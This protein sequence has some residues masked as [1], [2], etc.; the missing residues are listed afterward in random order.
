MDIVIISGFLG[1]GKTTTLNHFINSAK[2]Q[3]QTPAVIMN[4]FGS[5]SVDS[6]LIDDSIG[7]CE[8]INGCI[9][10]EM[11]SNVTDQ[12]HDIY[13]DYQPD[14]VFIECSGIAHPLEVL[15]AC[16]T[17]ILTP[18]S[19]VVSLTSVIDVQLYSKLEQL[20]DDIQHLIIAQMSHCSNFV[21]N[22]SD[23]ITSDQLLEVIESITKRHPNTPYFLTSHGKVTLD[24]IKSNKITKDEQFQ[25]GKIIH[26]TIGHSIFYFSH[27]WHKQSFINWLQDLPDNIYRVK[28]FL[29]FDDSAVKSLVQYANHH[30]DVVSSHLSI[31]DYLVVI[32]HNID[33]VQLTDS[34]QQYHNL[35]AN[36]E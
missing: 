31:E 22:K 30:L 1:G 8:I 25:G 21:L 12:L 15:D 4:E 9:C 5:R 35:N 23:L 2:S 11:K 16:L 6:H 7:L 3:G 19:N 13:I 18:F 20:P 14:V 24:N 27:S 36:Q 33:K 29:T 32:G 26:S 17:P 10:C 34:V 28:G